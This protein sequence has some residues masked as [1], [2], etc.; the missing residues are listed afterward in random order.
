MSFDLKQLCLFTKHAN[1]IAGELVHIITSMILV[2]MI[3]WSWH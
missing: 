2:T 3:S 1:M